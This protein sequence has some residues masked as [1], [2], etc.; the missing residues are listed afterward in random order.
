VDVLDTVEAYKSSDYSCVNIQ[1]FFVDVSNLLELVFFIPDV[2]VVATVE[3]SPCYS[4]DSWLR[5]ILVGYDDILVAFLVFS[6]P[7]VVSADRTK[8]TLGFFPAVATDV[9]S[10]SVFKGFAFD[11]VSAVCAFCHYW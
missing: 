2:E 5:L 10:I 11:T 9:I 7:L 6:F 3:W 1:F 8:E 4:V